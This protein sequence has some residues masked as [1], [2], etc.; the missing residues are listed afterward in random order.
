MGEVAIEGLD[1]ERAESGV[2][3]VCREGCAM[4]MAREARRLLRNMDCQRTCERSR[5]TN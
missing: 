5:V 4:S 2:D 1:V 3:V